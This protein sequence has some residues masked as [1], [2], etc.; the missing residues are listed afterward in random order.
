MANQVLE[1]DGAGG[2]RPA[3]GLTETAAPKSIW[4]PTDTQSISGAVNQVGDR[5]HDTNPAVG[6]LTITDL[7]G[8]KWHIDDNGTGKITALGGGKWHIEDGGVTPGTPAH[9]TGS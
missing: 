6:G 9:I 5:W 2:Y 1:D 7:G 8:G 3:A 4:G